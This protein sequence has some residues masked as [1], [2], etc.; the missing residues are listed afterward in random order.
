MSQLHARPPLRSGE[1]ALGPAAGALIACFEGR[2]RHIRRAINRVVHA[3]PLS[4]CGGVIAGDRD[5]MSAATQPRSEEH[6]SELQSHSDL[7]CRLL[8]EKKNKICASVGRFHKIKAST[9]RS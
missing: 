6:T 4:A 5:E 3:Q 2:V 9:P 1:V 7:V 8:L